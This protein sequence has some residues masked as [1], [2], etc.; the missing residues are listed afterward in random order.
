ML[1][2][3][4]FHHKLYF[5][6]LACMLTT[7]TMTSSCK[8]KKRIVGVSDKEINAV[9]FPTILKEGATDW[10]FF[11]TKAKV[12]FTYSTEANAAPI[13]MSATVSLRMQKDSLLWMSVSYFGME[14]LR[15]KITTDSVYVKQIQ[16][17]KNVTVK[18]IQELREMTP[19][20]DV[21][22]HHFQRLFLGQVLFSLT[23]YK[24]ITPT[25]DNLFGIQYDTTRF[26]CSQL[27]EYKTLNPHSTVLTSQKEE[28]HVSVEY[29]NIKA[30][31]LFAI[32]HSIKV[33]GKENKDAA[34]TALINIE[35]QNPSF[36]DSLTFPFSLPSTYENRSE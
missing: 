24:W 30:T 10:K 18:S 4:R 5:L 33:V 16:P 36:V 21:E 6:L 1:S 28:G 15:V 9:N 35:L 19:G 17:K 20:L 13:K 27:F 32:P 22:L 14:V 23:S 2:I 12:D 29:S 31:Q 25:P 7:L 26:S 3:T 8:S 34:V 11:S